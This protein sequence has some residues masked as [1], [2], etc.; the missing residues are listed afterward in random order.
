[1][2]VGGASLIGSGVT[3][4]LAFAE[5]ASIHDCDDERCPSRYS[6]RIRTH[7]TYRTISMITFYAGAGLAAAGLTLVLVAPSGASA[8]KP[9]VALQLGP[10]SASIRGAF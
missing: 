7:N 9:A 8:D 1:M 6:G 10:G 5:K 4:G 3:A 2:I